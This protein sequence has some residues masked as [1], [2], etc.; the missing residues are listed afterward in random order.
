MMVFES[1]GK[2]KTMILVDAVQNQSKVD[3]ASIL[4]I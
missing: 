1:L 2:A 3:F 4:T